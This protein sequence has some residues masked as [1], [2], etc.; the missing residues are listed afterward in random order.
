MNVTGLVQ[1]K[2]RDCGLTFWA[3]EEDEPRFCPFC[4]MAL[5]EKVNS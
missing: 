3:R 2:C 1:F 5:I 4:A